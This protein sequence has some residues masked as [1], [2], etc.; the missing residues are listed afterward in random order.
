MIEIY[1]GSTYPNLSGT[2]K[3]EGL[4]DL[5]NLSAEIFVGQYSSAAKPFFGN[6]VIS[7]K[8]EDSGGS[9]F[10]WEYDNTVAD[11]VSGDYIIYIRIVYDSGEIEIIKAGKV[12]VSE[13]T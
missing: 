13:F 5:T 8:V 10:A 12:S 4:I 11:T 9:S 1:T 7:N 6:V 2:V 3:W